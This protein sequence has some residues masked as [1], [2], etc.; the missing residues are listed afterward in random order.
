MTYDQTP[1]H[2]WNSPVKY[3]FLFEY[4]LNFHP[5]LI[6][7]FAIREILA[8]TLSHLT[9]HQVL[10]GLVQEALSLF[11]VAGAVDLVSGR[12]EISELLKLDHCIDLVIPRG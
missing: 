7:R 2:L 10:H 8:L 12:E 1:T 5:F 4:P 6:I 3:P 11:S 9:L